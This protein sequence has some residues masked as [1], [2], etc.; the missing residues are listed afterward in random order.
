MTPLPGSAAATFPDLRKRPQPLPAATRILPL[1]WAVAGS[2]LRA[3]DALR[4]AAWALAAGTRA[5]RY[6]SC[7]DAGCE[8]PYCQIWR[9]AWDEGYREGYADGHATGY[10]A[11][12]DA[13]YAAGQ[14]DAGGG[15]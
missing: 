6:Q 2:G 3:L 12:F 10:A 9:E 1:T 4:R 7:R 8:R 5:H 11:G 14:A 15:S 13:G